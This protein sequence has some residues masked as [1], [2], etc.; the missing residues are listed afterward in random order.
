MRLTE[1][2]EGQAFLSRFTEIFDL[3]AAASLLMWDQAT[4]M[5]EGGAK[6]RGRQLALLRRLAHETL[7]ASE[8]ARVL[9]SAEKTV[10][11]ADPDSVVSAMLQRARRDFER[12]SRV[13]AEFMARYSAHVSQTY[14]TWTK[15]KGAG[16][17]AGVAPLLEKT[18]DLSREYSG[19]FPGYNHIADPLIDNNDEGMTVKTLRILF[20]ELRGELM[21]LVRAIA[22]RPPVDDSKLRGR[23]D[24]DAQLRFG[25]EVIRRF[26]YDFTR[27]RQDKT[28]HPFM[29]KFSLGDVRITTRYKED[30]VTDALFSTMHEAGHALYEQGI[31]PELESTP[32]AHGVTAGVHESQSRLWENLVGRSLA[33]WEFYYP[34]L[35]EAFPEP[36]GRVPVDA[37]HRIINKVTPSLIR[38]DADEV[39]YN[40]HVMI[41][42]DLELAMLE[43]RLKIKDLPEAWNERYRSDLGVLPPDH[44]RGVMQDV[45]WYCDFIGGQFQCYTLGN[46][47]SAQFYDAAERALPSLMKDIRTGDFAPLRGWLKDNIHRHGARYPAD[48]LVQ[49]ATGGPLSIKPY[50]AYLKGKYGE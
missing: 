11:S 38:T 49:R 46:I 20:D 6:A 15:A 2:P 29:I 24:P 45:H 28:H 37:F 48:E 22:T 35:V 30:D 8:T 9:D 3:Q 23:Y 17:F 50:M 19:Y 34:K 25:E 13:P 26:G 21:P 1:S 5:P 31:D 39:T 47:L 12:A 7:I 14:D 40:L 32:L 43:G 42:F 4:Y 36:L 16:D 27:G 41:R 10:A 18:L 44:A 33:F